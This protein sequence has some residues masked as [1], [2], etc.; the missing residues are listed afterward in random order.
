MFL[1]IKNFVFRVV[2]VIVVSVSYTHLDV[3][4]RQL[5][6]TKTIHTKSVQLLPFADDVDVTAR[7]YR[8]NV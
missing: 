2:N 1:L 4:K 5:Q 8:N 6:R 3:Y 7:S